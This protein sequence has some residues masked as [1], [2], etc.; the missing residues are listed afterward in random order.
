MGYK[1]RLIKNLVSMLKPK[2]LNLGEEKRF[3]IL[4]TTGLGDTLWGTPA[5]RALRECF[6]TSYIGVVT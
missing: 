6:P 5:I 1:N 2:S 4:S 3:L